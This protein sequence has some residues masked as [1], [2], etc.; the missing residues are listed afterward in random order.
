MPG[1]ISLLVYGELSHWDNSLFD[2]MT[3]SHRNKYFSIQLYVL[4]HVFVND[5]I[6]SFN[7]NTKH[8]NDLATLNC[9]CHSITS[10]GLICIINHRTS[11]KGQVPNKNCNINYFPAATNLKDPSQTI[12]MDLS[13]RAVI[14][15]WLGLIYQSEGFIQ[16]KSVSQS[17]VDSVHLHVFSLH[18]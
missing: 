18:I 9:T 6:R 5:T 8:F 14:Y 16:P 2:R 4:D 1:E 7:W 11:P 12:R 15:E 13:N 3:R 10:V 17:S